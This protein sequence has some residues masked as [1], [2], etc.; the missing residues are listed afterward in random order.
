MKL[1]VFDWTLTPESMDRAA[2]RL[3]AAGVAARVIAMSRRAMAATSLRLPCSHDSPKVCFM[4][5]PYLRFGVLCLLSAAGLKFSNRNERFLADAIGSRVYQ[6]RD[7]VST[8]VRLSGE[9][10]P[11]LLKRLV[12][13][14]SDLMGAARRH[15]A[16]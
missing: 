6:R 10:K 13:R 15:L 14:R 5:V 9:S 12:R 7:L 3:D 16:L 8:R 11:R 4:S 1:P 2:W